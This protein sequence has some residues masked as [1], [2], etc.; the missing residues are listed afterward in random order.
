MDIQ[1]GFC[2]TIS[3]CNTRRSID[4]K[5][6]GAKACNSSLAE[7]LGRHQHE[8]TGP[9]RRCTLRSIYTK[10]PIHHRRF[11]VNWGWFIG[12]FIW[13]YNYWVDRNC[14]RL[15]QGHVTSGILVRL[16]VSPVHVSEPAHLL[17][18][19]HCRVRVMPAAVMRR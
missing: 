1:D 16:T 4:G 8:P 18:W 12:S 5:C 17:V 14:N 3:T 11:K 15:W 2:N 13:I 9:A 19:K 10:P 6:H 7:N